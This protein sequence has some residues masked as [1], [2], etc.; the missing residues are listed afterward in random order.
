[1]GQHLLGK[2]KIRITT[3]YHKTEADAEKAYAA[4]NDCAFS[5]IPG[6][7][8]NHP[9]QLTVMF[10]GYTPGPHGGLGDLKFEAKATDE[11][12]DKLRFRWFML[13]KE[14][15][16][17][18]YDMIASTTV[19]DG[20]TA[21]NV[22]LPAPSVSGSM[23]FVGVYDD[24]GGVTWK[25]CSWELPFQGMST[26]DLPDDPW[27]DV[28]MGK[29]TVNGKEVLPGDIFVLKNGDMIETAPDDAVTQQGGGYAVIRYGT[30]GTVKIIAN[31]R[32]QFQGWKTLTLIRGRIAVEGRKWEQYYKESNRPSTGQQEFNLDVKG[33]QT[34][35]QWFESFDDPQERGVWRERIK[36]MQTGA[37]RGHWA[38]TQFE[39]MADE[40]GTTTYY[41][42]EDF[43]DVSDVGMKKSV[44]LRPGEMTTVR[45]GGVPS[46]PVPFHPSVVEAWQPSGELVLKTTTQSTGQPGLTFE[47]RSKPTGSEVQIPLMLKGITGSTGNIDLTL[48]YDPSV[49]T[50]KEVLKGSLT[51]NSIFDYVISSGTIRV[52]LADSQGFSGDGSVAYV[53]FTV[54]GAEGSSSKL[55]IAQATAN[56]SDYNSMALATHDGLFQ[57]IGSDDLRGDCDGD[58][59]LSAVDALCALQMAVGKKAADPVMDVT[60]DGKVTSLDAR[61]ILQMAIQGG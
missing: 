10:L 46:D 19:Q 41:V 39:V 59:K 20:V 37:S 24:R 28:A 30:T 6:C 38:G 31:A 1:M 57:V 26:M 42:L 53:R 8:G 34:L 17:E 12:G 47:S 9:P 11:D 25:W 51:A 49:L 14:Y 23:I 52:S 61:E 58:G 36:E 35:E 21:M 40:D 43:V 48:A 56:A 45:P 29:V 50:A 5:M 4:L 3:Q 22:S 18:N 2:H 44:I 15:K 55:E 60:G 16:A 13:R 54:I 7:A 33:P 32:V 27:L